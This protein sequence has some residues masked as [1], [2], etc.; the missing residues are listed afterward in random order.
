MYGDAQRR[1][2]RKRGAVQQQCQRHR[3]RERDRSRRSIHRRLHGYRGSSF[4]GSNG[5]PYRDFGRR[6][7]D[8]RPDDFANHREQPNVYPRQPRRTRFFRMHGD[9]QRR[10]SCGGRKRYSVQ[11]QYQRHRS[12]EP[13]RSG[14]S[15]HRRLYGYRGFRFD[16]ADGNAYRDFERRISDLRPHDF[17]NADVEQPELYPRQPRRTRFLCLHGDT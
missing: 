9:A 3:S 6:L 2:G 5:D 13:D 4:D 15:N 11:Q 10:C 12:R 14:G 16:C 7:Q 1:R 17:N 8:F